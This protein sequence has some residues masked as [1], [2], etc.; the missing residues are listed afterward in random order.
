MFERAIRVPSEPVKLKKGVVIGALLE[1]IIYPGISFPAFP[2][3][4]I[5]SVT[6]ATVLSTFPVA[7]SISSMSTT[8]ALFVAFNIF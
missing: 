1:S 3:N 6:F 5:S 4:F 7:G 2:A 8:T